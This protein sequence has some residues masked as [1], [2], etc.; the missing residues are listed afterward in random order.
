MA[1]WFTYP[2][3]PSSSSDDEKDVSK[4]ISFEDFVRERDNEREFFHQLG[5]HPQLYAFHIADTDKWI[6]TTPSY[7]HMA[8]YHFDKL[9]DIH[10]LA[11]IQSGI[12]EYRDTDISDVQYG[13]ASYDKD[14]LQFIFNMASE[15]IAYHE[16]DCA[17]NDN[18]YI[19]NVCW[20]AS[21]II[22]FQQ[23]YR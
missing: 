14:T 4:V 11:R 19:N 1:Y 22:T 16:L 2:I 23:R 8:M 5:N 7:Y 15:W 18:E 9:V 20:M 3:S 12:S 6:W 13:E 21:R 17:V 10:T